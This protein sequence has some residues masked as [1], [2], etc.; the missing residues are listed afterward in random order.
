[1]IKLL[2]PLAW[3]INKCIADPLW[4]V[5]STAVNSWLWLTKY[6]GNWSE[7]SGF[8]V[9][10]PRFVNGL[11]DVRWYLKG[12]TW[13]ADSAGDWYPWL[14][15]IVAEEYH[16]DCDGA[17]VYGRFLLSL[18]GVRSRRVKLISLNGTW[19]PWQFYAHIVQISADNKLMIS[20]NDLIEIEGEW[21]EFVRNYFAHQLQFYDWILE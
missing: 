18:I 8:I 9:R 13:T 1:M 16:D 12:F 20:N 14:H 6:R 19:K 2:F 5:W 7:C 11:D 3:L 17:A 15:T 4:F 21:K 10:M